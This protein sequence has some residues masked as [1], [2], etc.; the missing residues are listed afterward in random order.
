MWSDKGSDETR[1]NWIDKENVSDRMSGMRLDNIKNTLYV[2]DAAEKM[3]FLPNNSVD[4]CITDPPYNYE[5][6]GKNWDEVEIERRRKRITSSSTLVKHIPYGSA[7]AGGKRD[8]RWYERNA[9][10]IL[11]YRDWIQDW[12]KELFRILKPGAYVFVFN[13]SRTIA[14]VQVALESVGFYARDVI[15]WR[16][17]SGIPKGL[18]ISKKMEKM[19]DSDSNFWKGWH[20][21]LRNE[22]EGIS[23][24]QKPLVDNYLTTLKEF[25]VGLLNTRVNPDSFQSNIIENI[26]RDKPQEYNNH[27][28]VKPLS[29]IRTLL[30]FVAIP[31]SNFTVIDPF[32][33]SGTTAVAAILEGVNYIGIDKSDVYIEIAKRRIGEINESLCQMRL[34]I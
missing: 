16:R 9:E 21:C 14:H 4:C 22:W 30:Q 33:G 29:L 17:N 6:I 12:A 7:L 25:S 5:F 23:L 20:S 34:D 19:G 28:T 8:A 10:N 32:I 27:P 2:G 31:N 24:V 15:V 13:S 18:N 11:T 26:S 1:N 3:R